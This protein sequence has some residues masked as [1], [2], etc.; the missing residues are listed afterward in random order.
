MHF[1]LQ[2]HCPHIYVPLASCTQPI[3]QAL[4]E[5]FFLDDIAE[6]IEVFE[7]VDYFVL[8]LQTTR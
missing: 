6:G 5:Q 4:Y 8:A 7:G 1:A 2:A 3:L